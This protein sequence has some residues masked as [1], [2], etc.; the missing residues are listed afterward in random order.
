MEKLILPGVFPSVNHMY[1]NVTIKGRRIRVKTKKA[2]QVYNDIIIL[3]RYW[4]RNNGWKTTKEKVIVRLWFFFP[5]AKR[6]DSHNQ[7]KLIAD[8]LEDAGIYAD[9][10]TALPRVMDVDIDRKNPRIEIEF[11]LMLP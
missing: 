7:I 4:M 11:E 6:R 1:R 5:D 10:K 3:T 9:D 2:E 8:A